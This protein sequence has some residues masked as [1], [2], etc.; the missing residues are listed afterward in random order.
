MGAFARDIGA[1]F[2][3]GVAEVVP[4]ITSGAGADGVEQNGLVI[5]R[6]DALS[7][8]FALLLEA[9]LDED[10]TAIA[11]LT[12]QEGDE[13]D[14]S[15]MADVAA[16]LQPEGA[17]ASSVLTLTGGSGGST[18]TGA[19]KFDVDLSSL[20]RYVRV[21]VELTLSRGATDTGT[22]AIAYILGGR[23]IDS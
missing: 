5:D 12:L 15:D 2:D 20:K 3:I 8:V 10:E 21:Q 14:G 6:Q 1:L 22:V 18:E 23:S 16:A 19:Y 9:T 7:A 4:T 17:A 13:S 11:Q